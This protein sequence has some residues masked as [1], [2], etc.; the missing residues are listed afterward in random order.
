MLAHWRWRKKASS[1]HAIESPA[2]RLLPSPLRTFRFTFFDFTMKMKGRDAFHD[3]AL[4]IYAPIQRINARAPTHGSF[5]Y[6]AIM[7]TG[8]GRTEDDDISYTMLI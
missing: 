3:A 7:R 8:S 1:A 4:T 2:A 5:I 6:D